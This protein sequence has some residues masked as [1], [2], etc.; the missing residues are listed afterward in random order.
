MPAVDA[1]PSLTVGFPPSWINAIG[2][3]P[4]QIKL[5]QA[6]AYATFSA[7]YEN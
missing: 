6:E 5:A 7:A 2:L 4:V 1:A 3:Q